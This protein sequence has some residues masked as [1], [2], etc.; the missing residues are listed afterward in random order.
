MNKKTYCF[1]AGLPRSGSTLLSSILNQ[2]PMIYSG[3]SS[4][5][6]NLMHGLE[7]MIAK[8][9]FFKA[10]PKEEQA[11]LMVSK[12][13]D[14]FYADVLKPVI[15]DKHRGWP[16]KI[17]YIKNYFKIDHPKIL[18]PVRNMDEILTSFLMLHRRKN[19]LYDTQSGKVNFID[20]MLIKSNSPLTD[21]NRC[22]ALSTEGVIG[23]AYRAIQQA[24]MNGNQDCLHFIE[25]NDL[26]SDPDSTMKKVYD[27]L[28]MD[29]YD[30]HDYGNLTNVNQEHDQ[31]VYGFA[32]MHHV[33]PQLKKT[34]SDPKDVLPQSILDRCKNTE[35]W[36]Q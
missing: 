32:D 16:L 28:E 17:D 10:Y 35:F 9:E 20:E 19:G 13:I 29:P 34:S 26:V 27:F 25:Y 31:E 18:V 30:S 8:D 15:V 14:H 12:V 23:V 7:E 6:L 4:P 2:N 36:R 22:I 24:M 5:V 1:M 33:R 3:P 11:G 21:E